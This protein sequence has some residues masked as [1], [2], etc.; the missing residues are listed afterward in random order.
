[1]NFSIQIINIVKELKAKHESV[2]SKQIGR[3]GALGKEKS[4]LKKA[5]FW[6]ECS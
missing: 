6:S 5:D 1:M 2:I 3:S 4:A